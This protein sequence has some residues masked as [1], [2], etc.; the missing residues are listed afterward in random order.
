MCAVSKNNHN[1]IYSFQIHKLLRSIT[2]EILVVS[3]RQQW[4]ANGEFCCF[5]DVSPQKWPGD[6][7]CVSSRGSVGFQEKHL[8]PVKHLMPFPIHSTSVTSHI[9]D[10]NGGKDSQNLCWILLVLLSFAQ[11][12]WLK[13]ELKLLNIIW[14]TYFS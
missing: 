5:S 9:Y 3:P 10:K 2:N 12:Y 11:G 4:S 7:T 8:R 13:L 1:E 6:L 14:K